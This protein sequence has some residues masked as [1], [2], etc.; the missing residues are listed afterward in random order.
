MAPLHLLMESSPLNSTT[1]TTLSRL[2]RLTRRGANRDLRDS[3]ERTPLDIFICRVTTDNNCRVETDGL[4]AALTGYRPTLGSANHG[5]TTSQKL[6]Q[7]LAAQGATRDAGLVLATLRPNTTPTTISSF[8]LPETD[9]NLLF[10]NFKGSPEPAKLNVL[11][12]LA[13]QGASESQLLYFFKL[14]D[15][16][17]NNATN[18]NNLTARPASSKGELHLNF[19]LGA[20]RGDIIGLA[21]KRDAALEAAGTGDLGT[22][23]T[24][25]ET[26]KWNVVEA[27]YHSNRT[28]LSLA[29]EKGHVEVVKYLLERGVATEVVDNS[30]RTA[31][32]WAGRGRKMDVVRVLVENGAVVTRVAVCRKYQVSRYIRNTGQI[33]SP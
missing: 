6:L 28:L 20:E 11:N 19:L 31:L 8:G 24:L 17:N 10:P 30:G 14:L 12:F 25:V 3:K 1:S 23:Q 27:V 32:Y 13:L 2:L 26:L 33:P 7:K 29:A 21:D 4:L 9:P 18:T 22:L 5:R 15:N 16:N